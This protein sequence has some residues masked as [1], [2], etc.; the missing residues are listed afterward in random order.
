MLNPSKKIK[1][2]TGIAALALLA[3]CGSSNNS[4]IFTGSS[5]V[6]NVVPI[7]AQQPPVANDDVYNVLGNATLNFTQSRSVLNN[8]ETN[9][10]VITSF[11]TTTSSGA[12][13]ALAAD[14]T[15]TYTPA[16]G[17]EGADTFTYT[18]SNALGDSTATATINVAGLALFVDVSQAS[19][20]NGTENSP[21]NDLTSALNA[22]SS[23]DTIFVLGAP[24]TVFNGQINLPQGVDLVGET[25]GLQ[26]FLQAIDNGV[27]RP[28]I[29]GPVVCGG[30]NTVAGFSIEGSAGNG[31]SGTNV[32]DLR[33][34][35]NV[36]VGSTDEHIRLDDVSGTV[37]VLN[38]SFLDQ[39][40]DDEN[41][42]TLLNDGTNAAYNLSGNLFGTDTSDPEDAVFVDLSGA[43]V[44]SVEFD[45][46]ATESVDVA[47]DLDYVF[48]AFLSDQ[49]QLDLRA[50]QNDLKR[51]DDS[52][53]YIETFSPGA[54]LTGEFTQNRMT[55]CDDAGVEVFAN[56]G[57]A[58]LT[59]TGN[60]FDDCDDAGILLFTTGVNASITA[61]VSGCLIFEGDE[62]VE[63]SASAP[64]SSIAIALRN[65]LIN[66]DPLRFTSGD[67]TSEVCVDMTGNRLEDLNLTFN[68][69]AGTINVE[70]L[71]NTVTGGPLDS[72]NSFDNVN[73][74]NNGANPVD[75]GFCGIP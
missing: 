14:G 62:A 26:L 20:G 33:V 48:R 63:V 61:V 35:N 72:A 52:A 58:N 53:F 25:Q 57:T 31:L 2:L 47:R 51:L 71:D 32:T 27:S 60:I 7:V 74:T 16:A 40:V 68:D 22:A 37:E 15:F 70:R 44:V 36:F 67:A 42:I 43:S 13:I 11:D 19:N 50:D 1:L 10:A 34:T 6:P 3:G 64:G 54:S 9:G 65:N 46:N 38:N 59:I 24:G 4:G 55:S 39:A 12:T 73:Q 8:D 28:I 23:G 75:A 66:G 17:F 49:A 56:T 30:D 45:E 18:L 5:G 41:F 29:T 21:F 69:T